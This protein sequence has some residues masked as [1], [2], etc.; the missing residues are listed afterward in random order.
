MIWNKKGCSVWLE[1]DVPQMVSLAGRPSWSIRLARPCQLSRP[2]PTTGPHAT[3]EIL[4]WPLVILPE[5]P[6]PGPQVRLQPW[7]P[8][9]ATA[10][11]N[12][13]PADVASTRIDFAAWLRTL[14]RRHR[15]IAENLAIG[16][17]A[18]A[19]ARRFR[20]SPARISQL[21]QKSYWAW[22]RFRGEDGAEDIG[23][24]EAAT[25]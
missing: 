3:H 25:A 19:V 10:A 22:L 17:R 11:L 6:V 21:R 5:R 16:E 9:S 4:L 8:S 12:A 18:G 15:K 1:L 7:R 13:L 23:D 20:V 24:V 14:P 2:L